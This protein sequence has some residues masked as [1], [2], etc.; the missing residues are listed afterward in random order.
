MD[1]EQILTCWARL[2]HKAGMALVF[3]FWSVQLKAILSLLA[4]THLVEWEKKLLHGARMRLSTREA[5]GNDDDQVAPQPQTLGWNDRWL[6]GNGSPWICVALMAPLS[7]AD[8]RS[9]C[10]W[11]GYSRVV[12]GWRVLMQPYGGIATQNAQ[13]AWMHSSIWVTWLA[14]KTEC[15][16][17]V[18]IKTSCT[19]SQS[20]QHAKTSRG[21]WTT[22]QLPR[23]ILLSFVFGGCLSCF[24]KLRNIGVPRV[25]QSFDRE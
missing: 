8:G 9:I 21:V 11:L 24:R 10:I 22:Q 17:C 25:Q 23:S 18:Q 14:V 19:Y 5:C 4:T 13:M 2:K 12:A 1:N 15:S 20:C 7:R 6:V 3:T 16:D